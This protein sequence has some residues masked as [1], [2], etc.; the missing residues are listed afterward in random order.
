MSREPEI[1]SESLELENPNDPL[2][3]SMARS[4]PS[5]V[6][7]EVTCTEHPTLIGRVRCRFGGATQD[8]RWFPKL[9][10]KSVV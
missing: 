2:D 5:L 9:D 8:E 1:R 7:A 10:R 3:L 6:V 4:L